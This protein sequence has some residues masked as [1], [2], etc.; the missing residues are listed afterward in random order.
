LAKGLKIARLIDRDDHSLE[1]VARLNEQ[2]IRVLS[3]RNIECYLFD[4]EVLEALCKEV[5]K[6]SEFPALKQEKAAEVAALAARKKAPDDLASAAGPI[7]VIVK[8]RLGLTAVGNDY[9]AFMRNR[10][11]PL[12][13]PHMQTY[14]ELRKAI[15]NK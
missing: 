10:L 11:A 2:N 6:E 9:A 14:K 7:Y 1:D 13:K 5:G 4:D 8:N 15:F 12:L 3:R